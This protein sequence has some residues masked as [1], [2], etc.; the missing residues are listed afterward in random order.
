M[1][2]VT[3]LD[4][5]PLTD[6]LSETSQTRPVK[7]SVVVPVWNS[8]E[9]LK[10]CLDSILAAIGRYGNGELIVVDNGSTDGSYEILSSEYR[11]LARIEQLKGATISAVRNRGGRLA[12]GKYLCF[13]DSDCLVP[14]NYLHQ[15]AAVFSSIDTD[16]TGSGVQ[17]PPSPH[18]IEETWQGLHDHSSDGYVSLMNSANFVIKADVFKVSGGFDEKLVTG[19]DAEYCQ[20]LISGGFR[21]YE[22]RDV[23]AV[24]L[25]NPKTAVAFFKK[26]AWRGL[27]MFGTAKIDWLDKPLLMTVAFLVLSAI[28]VAG[29]FIASINLGTRI[30]ALLLLSGFAPALTV[31]YRSVEQRRLYRP[32]RSALLYWVYYAGRAWAL[33]LI[34]FRSLQARN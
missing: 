24:H 25:R 30:A 20:R 31:V 14:E 11:E 26:E 8:R 10:G 22:A 34:L 5:N 15:V 32:L 21:V 4:G 17:L 33:F 27:G 28:G 18:W 6:V 16:A 2:D 23:S 3:P 13:I 19:E 1:P 12:A 9:Y 7:I 29:L